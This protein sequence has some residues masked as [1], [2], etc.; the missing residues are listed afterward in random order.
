MAKT[1]SNTGMRLTV[2]L[3][4]GGRAEL[5]DAFQC[6]TSRTRAIMVLTAMAPAPL[7]V[8]EEMIAENTTTPRA[9][10]IPIF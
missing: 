3:N 8:D 5:V 10:P 7:C 1:A 9:C 4:Y 6:H 2:A